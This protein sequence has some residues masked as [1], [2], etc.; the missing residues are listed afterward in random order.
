[1]G[2]GEVDE[3]IRGAAC[4]LPAV[5]YK[6]SALTMDTPLTPKIEQLI[7][8][9]LEGGSHQTAA[10]IVEDAPDALAE[11]EDF[12]AIRGELDHAHEQLDRGD[13]R[14]ARRRSQGP[15]TGASYGESPRGTASTQRTVT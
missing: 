11:R 13:D 2:G 7:R 1:M 10:E 12:G 5:R 3:L 9:R 6:K 14:Q 4:D 15:W 8:E